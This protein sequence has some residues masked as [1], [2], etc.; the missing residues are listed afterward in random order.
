MSDIALADGERPDAP[1]ELRDANDGDLAE[2]VSLLNRA[3]RGT[4]EDA[5]W[6]SETGL[7]DGDRENEPMLRQELEE[8][9]NVRLMVWTPEPDR[10]V[11]GCVLLE[12]TEDCQWYL[13]SLAVDPSV[14]NK[15]AGRRLLAAAEDLIREEGGRTVKMTVVESRQTLI[16]WYERRGYS[17]TGEL[18][19]FP[20][21]ETRFGIPRMAGLRFLVLSKELTARENLSFT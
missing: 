19:P 13:G 12:P 3:Y 8:K 7:I 17:R 15:Q 20:Y 1:L 2:V 11:R 16:G 14:Q 4:G 6:T 21:S 9:A 18:V 5:G 10:A